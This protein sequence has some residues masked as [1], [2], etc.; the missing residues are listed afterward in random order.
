MPPAPPAPD[1]DA[2]LLEEAQLLDAA[3]DA[4]LVAEDD[5]ALAAEEDVPGPG[6][7]PLGPAVPTPPAPP[8]PVSPTLPFAQLTIK[9]PAKRQEAAIVK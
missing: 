8:S 2:L 9:T 4:A 6:P 7:G 5:A 1:E 3:E